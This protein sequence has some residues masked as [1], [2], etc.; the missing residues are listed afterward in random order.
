MQED[1]LVSAIQVG[2]KADRSGRP[3]RIVVTIKITDTGS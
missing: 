1:A 2:Y 3:Y